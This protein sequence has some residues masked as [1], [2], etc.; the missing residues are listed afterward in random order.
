MKALYLNC[1]RELQKC[2]IRNRV[3]R[4]FDV[5][6]KN[7]YGKTAL[8]VARKKESLEILRYIYA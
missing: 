3:T 2:R 7:N 6:A 4:D 1:A 8:D 5:N